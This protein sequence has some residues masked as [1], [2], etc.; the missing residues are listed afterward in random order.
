MQVRILGPLEVVVDGEV[1]P[2][3]GARLRALMIRLALDAGRVVGVE[4]LVRALWPDATPDDRVHAL[5]SLVSRLRRALPDGAVI[6]HAPGGYR[7]DA[8]TDAVDALR[9]ERLAVQGRR[10]LRSGETGAA[11]RWLREAL[12]L[13]RGEALA[14]IATA[15]STAAAAMRLE[16]LRL[17]ATED[18]VAA[19]LQT[20]YDPSPLVAELEELVAGHPLRERLRGLLIRALHADGRHAE[21]LTAY[22]TF[23]RRLAHDLGSDPGPELRAIHLAVLRG[24]D[25]RSTA[26]RDGPPGNL[27]ASLTSFVGRAAEQA[28]L[29]E[30]LEQGRLV[31]LVGPGGAG[32]SRLATTVAA[33]TAATFVGGVWLVELAATAEPGEVAEAMVNTLGPREAAMPDASVRPS[34]AV[35]RLAAAMPAARTLVVL[36]N[37]EHLID[38]TARLVDGLLGR[39]PQ[40]HILATSREPLGIL[41]EALY[42]VHPLDRP[43]P[44]MSV[45]E[46]M[47]TPAA[48]LLVDR[49]RAV[50]ADFTVT[51]DNVGAVIEICRRL[52]GLPL[53]IELA[54]ARLRFSSVDQLAGRL[55]DRFRLLTGGSRTALPRHRTLRAVVAW[56]WDLLSDD[57]RRVA[58]RLAVFPASFTPGA[59]ARV[60]A[61]ATVAEALDALADRSLVQVLDEPA[62]RYRMLE[63]IREYALERLADAGQVAE[64]RAAHAGYFLELAERAEPH[65]RGSGQL[66]WIRTL[67]AERDNLLA[68]LRLAS[69]TGDADTAVRLVAALS[70]FWTIHGEHTEAVDRLRAALDVPGHASQDARVVAVAGYLFNSLLA[71]NA[72]DARARAPAFRSLARARGDEDAAAALIQATVA[73]LSDQPVAGLATVDR[74]LPHSDAWTAGMLWLTRSFLDASRADMPAMRSDLASAAAGFRGAGERWGLATSLTYL[75]FARATSGDFAGAVAAAAETTG[76]VR[77]LGVDQLQRVWLAMVRTHTGDLDAARADLLDIVSGG[78][79]TRQAE[80]ARVFLAGLARYDDDLDEATRQLDLATARRDA[81]DDPGFRV[82]LSAERGFLAVATGDLEA[83]RRSLLEALALADGMRDTPMVA[84]VGVGVAHLQLRCD[85]P[86][87]A[88]E[89]LGAAHAL[90]GSADALHPDVARLA[91][92]LPRRLGESGYRVAYDRGRTLS[93]ADAL[94]AID[95]HLRGAGGR[96]AAEA[97]APRPG[98]G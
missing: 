91:G 27:P 32:K 68:A 62:P 26:R 79:S 84:T 46:A 88:A 38:A 28:S 86:T 37:C 65:L 82:L 2:I 59:A 77:E 66:P 42:P 18:R 23:R 57:E 16:E 94:G 87:A 64:A 69:D 15:P 36:D 93:Q 83:A 3:S 30:L 78:A 6:R 60:C 95:G 29:A 25:V 40:L 55:D 80:L 8:P 35:T 50:R 89:L 39:C 20:A 47:T 4:S 81:P 33:D 22:E 10:A 97:A 34:D 56:S 52:D 24:D 53:A 48:Q 9:F 14:D 70:Y 72:A 74:Q 31:T 90:R 19:D 49:G 54:A 7:L 17:S 67:Q 11:A 76:L 96:G 73:L 45:A 5:Q 71:G 43:E 58:E 44:G 13:W 63:T 85:A 41:G 92:E 21:A 51:E 61:G 1:V 98:S 75:A 12:A